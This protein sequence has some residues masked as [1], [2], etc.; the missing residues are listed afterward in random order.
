MGTLGTPLNAFTVL[1]TGKVGIKTAA[2]DAVLTVEGAIRTI[3][4]DTDPCGNTDDYPE[5][6]IFYNST[7]HFYCFCNDS[8]AGVKMSDETA[9]CF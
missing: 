1:N 2:P 9:S 7:D 6:A 5:G 4:L 3:K 8:Q